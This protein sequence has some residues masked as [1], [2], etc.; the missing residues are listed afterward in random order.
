MTTEHE[1][2]MTETLQRIIAGMNLNAFMRELGYYN[3][4]QNYIA[5]TPEP[6]PARLAARYAHGYQED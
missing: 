5:G 2:D 6:D 4:P 3:P 1:K